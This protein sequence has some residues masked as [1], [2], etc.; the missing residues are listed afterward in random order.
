LNTG[1]KQD[2]IRVL[3]YNVLAE[4]YATI[5]KLNY[6]PNWALK[7][8]YRKGR[9]LKEIIDYKAEI[10]CLQEVEDKQYH[11]FF[12]N[13]LKS[14]G[15]DSKYRPK[16]RAKTMNDI[17]KVDGCA[18]FWQRDLFTYVSETFIEYQVLCLQKHHLFGREAMER[19]MTKDNIAVAVLLQP[20]GKYALKDNGNILVVNTHIHWDPTHVDVKALQVQLLIEEIE[21]LAKEYNNGSL[22]IPIIL[23]GDFNSIPTSAVYQLLS[24]G[25][26]EKNHPDFQGF[27]YGYYTNNG[28]SHNLSL[29][30][31]YSTVLGKEPDYTNFTG[32]FVGV[33]DYIWYT[34]NLL[35]TK[36]VLKPLLTDI[37][38]S[39]NGALPNPWICSDHIPILAE[40]HENV[41]QSNV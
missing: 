12:K 29:K 26:V 19:L 10:I 15:Y 9:I 16:S 28:L 8:S 30:S 3:C 4:S 23:A 40:I 39:H 38:R 2:G 31:T 27:D 35:T 14:R 24:T 6:C 37:V 17:E 22:D 36:K 1:I 18:I 21:R 41:N 20:T 34:E 13:Q 11:L 32:N 7:W 33:L 5:E 25:R